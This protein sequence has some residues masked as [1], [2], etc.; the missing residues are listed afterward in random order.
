MKLVHSRAKPVS[1]AVRAFDRNINACLNSSFVDSVDI[2]CS[3][4]TV[5]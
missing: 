5:G 1:P 3:L 2:S 4:C